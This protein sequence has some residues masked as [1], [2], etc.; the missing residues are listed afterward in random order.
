MS[1]YFSNSAHE[2]H[3]GNVRLCSP[4]KP[5]TTIADVSI[6]CILGFHNVV[7]C[8]I[9]LFSSGMQGRS[10]SSITLRV[11]VPSWVHLGGMRSMSTIIS[12]PA[13][14]AEQGHKATHHLSC[15]CFLSL[16]LACLPL[17]SRPLRTLLLISGVLRRC[18]MLN[19][20]DPRACPNTRRSLAR[21]PYLPC[22]GTHTYETRVHI[23]L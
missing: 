8:V 19:C 22:L 12:E 9:E 5:A 15:S 16:L 21:L 13:E 10:L 20:W 7:D 11:F 17:Y 6:R 1:Y 18:G 14:A 3:Q 2:V 4:D 23:A